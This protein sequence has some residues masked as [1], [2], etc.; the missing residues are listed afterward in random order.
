MIIINFNCT[1]YNKKKYIFLGLSN[2]RIGK[3]I[4]I[5]LETRDKTNTCLNRGGEPV[6][7]E[8]VYRDLTGTTKTTQIPVN[9]LRNGKYY[10]SFVPETLGKLLLYVYVR[11]HP[12]KVGSI[13]QIMV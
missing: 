12:I 2:V 3:K 1:I 13:I 9:D 4:E 11:G 10:I 7:S 6:I 8:I 5:I